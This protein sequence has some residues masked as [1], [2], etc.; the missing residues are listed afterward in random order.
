MIWP[1]NL[2]SNTN[3]FNFP[4][5]ASCNFPSPHLPTKPKN[6]SITLANR[7]YNEQLPLE[8]PVFFLIYASPPIQP[9]P[10]KLK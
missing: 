9:S 3:P 1:A 6:L 2:N 5:S 7:Y 10:Q 4:T 8:T